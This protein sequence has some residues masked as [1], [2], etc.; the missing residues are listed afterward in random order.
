MRLTNLLF[1]TLLS[2]YYVR[3]TIEIRPLSNSEV[4]IQLNNKE[5]TTVYIWQIG[6]AKL[7]QLQLKRN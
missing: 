7:K 6:H 4:L 1:S 2:H 3:V 5:I